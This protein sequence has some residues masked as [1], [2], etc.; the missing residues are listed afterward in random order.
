MIRI[1]CNVCNSVIDA[2]LSIRQSIESDGVSV[3]I[4]IS[5]MTDIDI[6]EK[7]FRELLSKID[8]V[9]NLSCL[10]ISDATKPG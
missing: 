2:H 5:G 1:H 6:C 3:K 8:L 10:E 4:K 7:C 9:T